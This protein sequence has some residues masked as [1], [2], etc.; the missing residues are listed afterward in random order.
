MTCKQ[1]SQILSLEYSRNLGLSWQL[2]KYYTLNINQFYIIHEDLIDEIKYDYILIRFVFLSNIS[3]CLKLEQV[4]KSND[5]R[6]FP[7]LSFDRLL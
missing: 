1:T 3:K 5:I 2:F 4:S 6:T 7:L